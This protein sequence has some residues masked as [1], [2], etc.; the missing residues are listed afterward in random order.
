MP[1]FKMHM[2]RSPDLKNNK[3]DN[4]NRRLKGC[5]KMKGLKQEIL[6]IEFTLD[7]TLR[8]EFVTGM[9]AFKVYYRHE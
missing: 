9:C 5:D 3:P 1:L 8:N 4:E 2:C 7:S 6:G